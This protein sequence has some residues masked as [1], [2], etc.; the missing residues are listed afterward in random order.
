MSSDA[1]PETPPPHNRCPYAGWV[2]T[3]NGRL[4]FRHI[5]E[6]RH[7]T[8][9]I[10]ANVNGDG[11][12]RLIIGYQRRPLS[13]V[14][15]K[16]AIHNLRGIGGD[17][18]FAIAARSGAPTISDKIAGKV[19]IFKSKQ[20]WRLHTE[21]AV[22]K[23]IDDIREEQFSANQ[24]RCENIARD[25]ERAIKKLD[26]TADIHLSFVLQRTGEVYFSKPTFR[27]E[28]LRY[29]SHDYANNCGHDFDKWVSDQAYFYLRD[30]SHSHQ[31]HHPASDTIL[32]LQQRDPADIEWRKYIIYSLYYAVIKT[33]RSSDDLSVFQSAAGIQAY[34]LSF[35]RICEHAVGGDKFA[36]FPKFNDEA[37][38]QSLDAKWQEVVSTTTSR[39]TAATNHR[40]YLLAISAIV[41]AILAIFVQPRI[42]NENDRAAFPFLHTVSDFI[43]GY[44]FEIIFIIAVL[45]GLVFLTT[46][47]RWLQKVSFGRDVLEASNIVRRRAV[48]FFLACS[49]IVTFITAWV[50]WPAVAEIIEAVSAFMLLFRAARP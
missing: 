45:A 36:N 26:E 44:F 18:W 49:A 4:S 33:K 42:N 28:G 31:H 5:G 20:D 47:A 35:Q 19:Y 50:F 40:T 39:F 24:T 21:D 38:R 11:Q 30:I 27:D 3:V 17:F 10:Y 22:R 37:L 23:A 7:P 41:I 16:W 46:R 32:I 8:D 6:S 9:S 48:V 2:P 43:T 1:S 15:F 14:L 29:A 34:C 12:W 25:F 13:D